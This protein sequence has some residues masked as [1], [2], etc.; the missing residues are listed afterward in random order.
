MTVC[1][2]SSSSWNI[3]I[4][5]KKTRKGQAILRSYLSLT[6]SPS[7]LFSSRPFR[8]V[9]I[10]WSV[11]TEGGLSRI[12]PQ[13]RDSFVR[14]SRPFQQTQGGPHRDEWHCSQSKPPPTQLLFTSPYQSC[15]SVSFLIN[16][17]QSFKGSDL[18]YISVQSLLSLYDPLNT[19][20]E[21]FINVILFRVSL[22]LSWISEYNSYCI[23]HC[24][25]ENTNFIY[26]VLKFRF[27]L[28]KESKNNTQNY[29]N[30]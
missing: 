18:I 6:S 29:I 13:W 22:D 9:L 14:P 3:V 2:L 27:C 20:V 8:S 21:Y 17:L 5:F 23:V 11:N 1:S 28:P 10:V 25:F 26:P 30:S 15:S 4:F 19:S 24:L 16:N 7:T 12:D